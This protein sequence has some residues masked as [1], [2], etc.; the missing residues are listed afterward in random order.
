MEVRLFRIFCP[1]SQS[2]ELATFYLITL[3][4]FSSEDDVEIHVK[5]EIKIIVAGVLAIILGQSVL[6]CV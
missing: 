6:V 1:H 2:L 5:F 3:L 4:N